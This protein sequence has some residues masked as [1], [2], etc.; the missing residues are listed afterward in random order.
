MEKQNWKALISSSF[1][2]ET[3]SYFIPLVNENLNNKV[4][5]MI[6]SLDDGIIHF[7][8][9]P[10]EAEKFQRFDCSKEPTIINK[11]LLE[12]KN[13]IK[14]VN[15]ND[16]GVDLE[17]NN[18]VILKVQSFPFLIK[19]LE[20]QKVKMVIN[21]DDKLVFENNVDKDKF[22]EMFHEVEFGKYKESCKNGPTSIAMSFKFEDD[23]K[24]TGL[25]SHTLS[26]NLPSTIKDGKEITDPIRF[27]NTDNNRYEINS[28]MS[29]YGSIPFLVGHNLDSSSGLFW[30][31]PSETWI[32][33]DTEE[34]SSR[35]ISETGF[36]DFFIVLGS[37]HDVIQAYTSLTGKP[38]LPQL[39]A[40]GYHQCRWTYSSSNEIRE[41]SRNL[42]NALIPHDALWLDLDHTDGKKYFTFNNNFKDIQKLTKEFVRANRRL[43]A[44]VDPHLKVERDYQ[45]YYEAKEGSYFIKNKNK[46]DY[47]ANCWPGRSGWIDFMN[48]N[49]REWWAN[50]FS[51]SLYRGSSKNLYI[52]NDM[53][54]PSVFNVPDLTL[55]R[56]TL[57]YGGYED[58]DVHNLYGHFMIMA[59]Y[60][61]LVKRNEDQNERPFLL[62]RS[63]FSGSQKYAWMWTGDNSASWEHLKDSISQTLTLGV[64]G[65]PFS[66]S[67]VGG[68]FDSPDQ[69]LLYRWYQVGAFCYPF[70]RCHCH[71]L[72]SRREP[73]LFKDEKLEAVQKAIQERYKLLPLWYT[74]SF[75]SYQTG[76][77]IIRPLWMEFNEQEVQEINTEIMISD[78]LLVAPVLEKS[79]SSID[80]YLPRSRWYEFRT[81]NEVK[82]S[83]EIVSIRDIEIDVPVFIRGGK[84]FAIKPNLRKSA[85][86]M[87]KDP[88]NLIVALD[89]NY[90]SDGELYI[91][92]GHSFDYLKN[93]YIHN[94]YIFENNELKSINL[95]ESNK[96]SD[97]YLN[98][99]E[100]INKIQITGL[101]KIPKT[102]TSST[103]NPI[104]FEDIDGVLNIEAELPIKEEWKLIFEF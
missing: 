71:H 21:Y 103:N 47:I 93:E 20:N 18:G 92:D 86:S 46:R 19:V 1:I 80:T 57:H 35:F 64:C 52:W 13:Q 81:L 79:A 10:K 101:Q 50:Q 104:H 48:P 76:L 72:S 42:D 9:E 100:T 90:Y 5:M 25:P 44:Q 69:E 66:G 7:K 87:L 14:E 61:G 33:I 23:V 102:I 4:N 59:T 63:F 40:L 36:I 11:K 58:R 3:N 95:G 98:N 89:N 91:D 6:S 99:S 32:D 37:H 75:K 34:K 70:F 38:T 39:F 17:F 31:N 12:T 41:V 68:F 43:V 16:N 49:A 67:D 65:F 62:T 96:E 26:L 30:C 28:V 84:T 83:G 2:S 56:D 24:F 74:S 73:Y 45:V 77:P 22:P 15:K 88:Y 54:E 82:K 8:V 60:D 78:V 53:N 29:L 85:L 51:Y 55:P 94:K 27:F 97:F